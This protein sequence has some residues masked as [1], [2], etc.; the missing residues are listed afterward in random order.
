MTG[1]GRGSAVEKNLRPREGD[2]A[3]E[4]PNPQAPVTGGYC[5]CCSLSCFV[6]S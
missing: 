3:P 2:G 6:A 4:Y 1:D 5:W